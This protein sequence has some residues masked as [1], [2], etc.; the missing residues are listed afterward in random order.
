M[1]A[2][3]AAGYIPLGIAYGILVMQL[4][5]PWW[6]APALSLAAYSGSAELLVITLDRKSVV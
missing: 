4:G 2:P 3:I 5:M 6:M 1:T